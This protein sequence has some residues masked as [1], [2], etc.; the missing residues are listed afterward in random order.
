MAH[1]DGLELSVTF[2]VAGLKKLPER[3][4]PSALALTQEPPTKQRGNGAGG[5]VASSQVTGS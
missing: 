5:R 4:Y 2:G 1:A 3:G